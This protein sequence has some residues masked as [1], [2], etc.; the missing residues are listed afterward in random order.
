MYSSVPAE[1][2]AR[3][4]ESLAPLFAKYGVDLVLAGHD[5]A[6]ERSQ[7]MQGVT[8]LV[9]GG[10]GAASYESSAA[11]PAHTAVRSSAHH[12]TQ[13]A[14]DGA[15][16]IVNVVDDRGRHLDGFEID[17]KTGALQADAGV[18]ELAGPLAA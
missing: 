6:Y 18:R 13:L 9:T 10:G 4:R 1:W 15:R 2:A 11:L 16:L 5:H 17:G 7:T 8:Y 14:F 12:W 3:E